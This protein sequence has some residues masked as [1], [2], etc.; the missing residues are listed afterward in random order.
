[1]INKVKHIERTC[2]ACPTQYEG[3]FEDGDRLYIRYR[4]GELSVMKY[5]PNEPSGL[6]LAKNE[7]FAAQVG[8]GLDG[9]MSDAELIGLVADV[10]TF[11]ITFIEGAEQRDIQ[12]NEEAA[13]GWAMFIADSKEYEDSSS[14]VGFFTWRHAKY[15][16]DLPM[17]THSQEAE[18]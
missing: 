12:R 13:R 10:V 5:A 14:D 11:P 17:S 1:M 2:D 18:D 4:W 16:G 7:L 3:E 8:E 15:H 6:M 9:T